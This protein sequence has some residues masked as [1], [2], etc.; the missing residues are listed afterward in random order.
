M[1]YKLEELL[2]NNPKAQIAD[3]YVELF[4]DEIELDQNAQ[5]TIG[6]A[7]KDIAKQLNMDERHLIKKM[8]NDPKIYQYPK[9][10][11]LTF[12]FDVDGNQMYVDIPDGFWRLKPEYQKLVDEQRKK[13]N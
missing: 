7:I 1:S 10:G 9:L 12:V 13:I 6:L 5:I 8:V 2:A 11:L 4:R 3:E